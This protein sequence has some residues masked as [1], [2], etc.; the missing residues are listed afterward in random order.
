MARSFEPRFAFGFE[1]QI[2]YELTYRSDGSGPH[3]WTVTVKGDRATAAPG[4]AEKP[5]LVVRMPVVDFV[6]IAANEVDPAVPLLEGR[7]EVEGDWAM[8]P[9]LSEMF[10]GKSNY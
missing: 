8:L 2:Q 10:G 9:R 7:I 3:R 5:T 4:A 6:R 1:G